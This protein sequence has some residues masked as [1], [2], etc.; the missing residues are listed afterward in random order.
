[1]KIAII[2]P[3]PPIKGGISKETEIIY[4]NIKDTYDV[5]IISFNRLYPKF[6]YPSETQY[7]HSIN[8]NDNNIKYDIDI[9]NPITWNKVARYII[10]NKFTHVIFRYWNPFFIPLYLFINWKIKG[11]QSNI[12][13]SCICD[14]IYPHESFFLEKYF[15]KKFFLNIDNFL[16]MSSESEDKLRSLINP[17]TKIVKSFLPLKE[18]INLKISKKDACKKLGIYNPPKLLLLFFGFIRDYKGLDILIDSLDS[19]KELDIKL[20]IAGESYIKTDKIKNSIKKN[21]LSEMIIWHKKYI[22]NEDINLYF[23]ACD[24]VVLPYKKISQS[25]IVPMAYHFDK[26]IVCS[27][28]KSLKEHIVEAE[29]GYFFKKNNSKHLSSIISTI[30]DNHDFKKS[31]DYINRFKYKYSFENYLSHFEEL[32]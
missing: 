27:D 28:I 26:L 31:E 20:L 8:I 2:S 22:S 19:I 25:G 24:I 9:L 4:S 29:T 15:I 10:K 30:Y 21:S 12:K 16:V 6:L 23:S 11:R 7:D 17:K 3:Y 1:M 5:S 32:L 14:N 13:I 18:N